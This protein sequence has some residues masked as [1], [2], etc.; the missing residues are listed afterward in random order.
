MKRP[1][2]F[3]LV[4]FILGPALAGAA[5]IHGTVYD[6]SLEKVANVIVEINSNPRQR[7]VA[8]NGTYNF[9]VPVGRYTLSTYSERG[10]TALR[11]VENITIIDDGNYVLDL[12]LYPDFTE[13]DLFE[14]VEFDIDNLYQEKKT[15][16]LWLL[17]P[18]AALMSLFL[19]VLVRVNTRLMKKEFEKEIDVLDDESHK[20]LALLRK[21]SGRMPQKQIRKE[22]PMSEAKI[23]LMIAE[24]ESLEKVK[25]VKKGRGNIILL[26]K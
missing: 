22:M 3:L 11:A 23:S 13:E 5:M 21:N 10:N 17:F 4:F 6:L 15:S 20:I 7:Y 19:V 14:D 9:E 24:L 2:L 12:F 8:V 18:L 26:K 16:I 1:V 25:K